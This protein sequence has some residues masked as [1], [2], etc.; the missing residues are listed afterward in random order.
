MFE[1]FFTTR[2]MG[3]GLG[4]AAVHGIARSHRGT[5][6]VESEVGKGTIVRFLLPAI[7]ADSAEEFEEAL[8]DDAWRGSGTALVIDD[9]DMLRA[10]TARMLERLNFSVLQAAD[11][12]Q[13]LAIVTAQSTAIACVIL[14]TTM[15]LLSAE[16]TLAELRR[17]N[18]TIPVLLMTG[19]SQRDAVQMLAQEHTDFVQKPVSIQAL[20]EKL[21]LLLET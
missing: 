11:G 16:Q 17:Q 9:D 10:V 7:A 1:P 19:Y 5:I 6:R 20:S 15:P 4:L 12:Y 18:P 3:R 2:F 13:G 8:S 14:D 21:R